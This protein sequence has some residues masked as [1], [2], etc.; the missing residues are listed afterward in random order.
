MKL[1]TDVSKN[2][3]VLLTFKVIFFKKYENILNMKFI[4]FCSASVFFLLYTML[5]QFFLIKLIVDK[6]V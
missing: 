6:F 5:H 1:L 3:M 2:L 4:L